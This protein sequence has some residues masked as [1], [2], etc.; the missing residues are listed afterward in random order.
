A[1][2]HS[3]DDL[4]CRHH[5]A[6][7]ARGDYALRDAVAHQAAGD[8][9]RRILLDA[10]SFR[11]RVLHG[12][13]LAGVMDLDRQTCR[14]RMQSQLAA[15]GPF[16]AHQNH[17]DLQVSRGP[18]RSLNFT[19]GGVIATHGIDRNGQ[20]G[21]ARTTLRQP[22]SLR[23]PCTCRSAGKRDGAAWA[24]GSW[25]NW[26]FRCE[27][28]DHA[29]AAWRSSA[30]NVVVWDLAFYFLSSLSAAQRLSTTVVRQLH[31]F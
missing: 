24:H 9:D 3:L 22:Q 13:E 12:D 16:Q 10:D 20:H 2:N 29:P 14:L 25:G 26:T 31:S 15:Q 21:R 11:C 19:L 1:P 8:T 23:G 30:W 6:G 7:I 27:A 17:S 4:G 18:N 28:N 5:G